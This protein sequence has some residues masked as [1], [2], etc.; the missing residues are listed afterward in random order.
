MAVKPPQ[1]PDK[2]LKI[3]YLDFQL[4]TSVQGAFLTVK[5]QD[6]M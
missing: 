4:I 3:V 6:K 2:Q 5:S 1:F